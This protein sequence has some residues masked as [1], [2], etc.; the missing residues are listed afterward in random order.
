VD[1]RPPRAPSGAAPLPPGRLRDGDRERAKPRPA[2]Y[3]D[4]LDLS[5]ADLVVAS[6]AELDADELLGTPV[7]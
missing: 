3:L 7:V 1:R 5:A 6:L 2:L 4:A